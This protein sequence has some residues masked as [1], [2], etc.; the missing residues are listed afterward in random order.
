MNLALIKRG[1][2][3]P[4]LSGCRAHG[5][6][7]PPTPWSA[8]NVKAS[9]SAE[10]ASLANTAVLHVDE[11]AVIASSALLALGLPALISAVRSSR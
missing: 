10:L 1:T 3:T 2:G 4:C 11:T 9:F 5:L 8:R 6:V 7:R